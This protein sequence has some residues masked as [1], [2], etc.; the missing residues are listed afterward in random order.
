[1]VD[2]KVITVESVPERVSVFV[3]AKVLEF[4]IVKTPVVVVIV[5]PL[6]EVAVATP[7]DGVVNEGETN[8]ALAVNCV[9]IAL[10]TP[11]T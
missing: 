11:L 10:V 8:G 5:S 3:T 4:V 7:S 9:W 1:V 2:G 6:I